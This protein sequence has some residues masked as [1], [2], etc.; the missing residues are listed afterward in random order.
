MGVLDKVMMDLVLNSIP[1]IADNQFAIIVNKLPH[2]TKRMLIQDADLRNVLVT[3]L[4]NNTKKTSHIFLNEKDN[5]LEDEDNIVKPVPKE[6]RQ[7]ML[8]LSPIMVQKQNV[9]RIAFESFDSMLHEDLVWLSMLTPLS[10]AAFVGA[11]AAA[12]AAVGF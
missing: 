11:S 3:S 7:F 8:N 12:T 9:R 5:E 6:L 10:A 1:T 4:L 2:K